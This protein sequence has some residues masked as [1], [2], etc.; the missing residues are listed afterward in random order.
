[1]RSFRYRPC[2]DIARGFVE[3]SSSSELTGIIHPCK[4]LQ[5]QVFSYNFKL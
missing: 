5:N 2:K 1:M 3:M 4:I